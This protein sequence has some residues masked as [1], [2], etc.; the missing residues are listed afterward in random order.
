MIDYSSEVVAQLNEK[1]VKE[2]V[3]SDTT[4]DPNHNT[5][6]Y[7]DLFRVVGLN[8]DGS[9]KSEFVTIGKLRSLTVD[10]TNEIIY[11][12]ASRKIYKADPQG[13]IIEELAADDIS[14]FALN[15]SF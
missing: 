1:L 14:F 2:V 5:I 11:Y 3:V 8:Y 10:P 7:S 9:K 4:I 12:T 13:E 6:Y 15:I